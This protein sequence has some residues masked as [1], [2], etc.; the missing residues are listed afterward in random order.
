MS[1]SVSRRGFVAGAAG[2]GAMAVLAGL[3][4]CGGSKKDDTKKDAGDDSKATTKAKLEMVTD[5]GGVNDQSFNQLAWEGMQQLQKE[6][7]WDVSYLESKQ[8][9]D[10]ATNLDKAVDDKSQLVWG[11]G[12][13]MADAIVEAAKKNSDVQFAIIDNGNDDSS[14]SNLTGVTF[15]AQEPSF[16]VGYIAA[17]TTKTGKVGFCH[18]RPV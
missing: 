18:H 7:G 11:V 17:R 15:R 3:T 12:F 5:T 16:L 2:A 13:A 8:E 14:I 9:S 6:E 4:A 1:N 10:Y